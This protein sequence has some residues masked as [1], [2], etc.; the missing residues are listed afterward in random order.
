MGSAGGERSVR[1]LATTSHVASASGERQAPPKGTIAAG[2]R[3]PF[4]KAR[5]LREHGPKVVRAGMTP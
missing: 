1:A 2:T 3:D 5:T 4:R